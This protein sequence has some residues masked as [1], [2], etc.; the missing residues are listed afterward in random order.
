MEFFRHVIHRQV[1]SALLQRLDQPDQ[2]IVEHLPL[3]HL[4]VEIVKNHL[5]RGPSQDHGQTLPGL[6]MIGPILA[7]G[8]GDGLSGFENRDLLG[9]L[10]VVTDLDRSGFAVHIRGKSAP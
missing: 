3:F 1:N 6:G 9:P 10:G 5:A 8:K 7:P 4:W 2:V